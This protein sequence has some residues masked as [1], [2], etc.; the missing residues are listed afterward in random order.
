[1]KDYMQKNSGSFLKLPSPVI[2]RKLRDVDLVVIPCGST[3]QHGPHL[4]VSTDVLIVEGLLE[5]AITKLEES[6]KSPKLFVLP[7]LCFSCSHE[8][9]SFPGTLSLRRSTFENLVKDIVFSI[10]RYGTKRILIVNGHGGNKSLEA[11]ARDIRWETDT[12]VYYYDL[13]QSQAFRKHQAGMDMHAGYCETSLMLALY[14]E[15]VTHE[16]IPSFDATRSQWQEDQLLQL[17]AP[18]KTEEISLSGVIGEAQKASAEFGEKI[19]AY[20]TEEFSLLITQ[21][22]SHWK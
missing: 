6:P 7:A 4:P 2:G 10:V 5:R 19:I 13:G 3:E 14:P 17:H 21:L 20:F 16:A 18:W 1:M 11:V 22:C 12:I 9:L 8:H 15:L